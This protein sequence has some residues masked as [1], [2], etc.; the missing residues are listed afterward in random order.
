MCYKCIIKK[1]AEIYIKNQIAE[2]RAEFWVAQT[3]LAQLTNPGSEMSSKEKTEKERLRKE[4]FA[5]NYAENR[6]LYLGK[7]FFLALFILLDIAFNS[8]AD[9]DSAFTDDR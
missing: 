9:H 5:V 6:R 4:R 2:G 3:A 8:I 1:D 7:V